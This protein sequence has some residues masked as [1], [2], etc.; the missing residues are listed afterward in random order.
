[1]RARAWSLTTPARTNFLFGK[2]KK[3]RTGDWDNV[4]SHEE[5]NAR[6]IISLLCWPIQPDNALQ[7]LH[8]HVKALAVVATS[9]SIEHVCA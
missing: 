6:W 1:M 8:C 9:E 3:G 2:E 7:L 4:R 5:R